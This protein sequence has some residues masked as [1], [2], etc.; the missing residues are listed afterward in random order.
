MDVITPENHL[1]TTTKKSD[2]VS[3]VEQD[4]WVN[5]ERCEKQKHWD[6]L[7]KSIHRWH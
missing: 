1:N 5:W 3:S 2:Y 6:L 4:R 7:R